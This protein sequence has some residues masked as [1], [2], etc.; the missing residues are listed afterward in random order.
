[1]TRITIGIFTDSFFPMID[2]VSFVIDNY[3]KRLSKVANVIV[4]APTYHGHDFDDSKFEYNIVR[5]K[6]IKVPTIDYSLPTPRL[7]RQFLRKLDEYNLD[8]VHIH[9]PFTL[10]KLGISYAKKHNIPVV[11]TM[12]SQ[13]K[14]DFKRTVKSEIIASGLNRKL[15]KVFNKCDRCCAVNSE[16]A[17]IFHE[18]YGY[19]TLPIVTNN[20]TEMVP[21]KN[22]RE[23]NHVINK[24]Y[25]IKLGEK[26][27]LF[28]GRI[29]KL[30]NVFFIV[31]SLKK[32]KERNPK[33]K[34]KMLFVGTGQDE[35][36][37][38]QAIRNNNLQDQV[39]MCGKITDRELLKK[40]YARADLF[41]FPS[42]Y[43]ASSLVQ[44]EA[45]SQSTPTLFLKGSATSYT[46][47]DNVNGF[48]EEYDK[49]KY[50]DRIIEIMKNK[51]LYKLVSENAFN[52][53]YVTW[54]NVTEQI[55]N[56]YIDLID[57]KKVKSEK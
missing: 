55:Y 50:A 36:E 12:H 8:I 23:A 44:V 47:L 13:Y 34:F 2:G 54:E 33:F 16:V 27:F 57:E 19:K 41:L 39:I 18:E 49:E 4:F 31:D 53:L 40:H 9:S 25:G 37:L 28:V 30:K 38:K 51:S 21:V 32:L 17:R 15:I 29:N 11:G 42:F 26:V 46:V 20:A 24:K 3:A 7:D 52:D 5:C 43:D 56:L 22:K 48:I 1:M 35:E 10:G 14:R 45:A 6:A